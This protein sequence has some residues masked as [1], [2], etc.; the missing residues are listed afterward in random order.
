MKKISVVLYIAAALAI[1]LGST[2]GALTAP[3]PNKPANTTVAAAAG[4]SV[5]SIPAAA[6]RPFEDG[7]DYQNDG[8]YLVH[9]HSPG[10]G[11][12]N[13]WYLAPVHLPQG[14]TITR[15][16]FYFYDD[17]TSDIL[18]WLQRSDLAGNYYNMASVDSAGYS[19]GWGNRSTTTIADPV[20]DNRYN[21]YWVIWDGPVY[22]GAGHEASGVTMVIEYTPPTVAAPGRLSIP[23]AAFQPREDGYDYENHGRYLV[24]KAGATTPSGSFAAPVQLPHGAT[25][26]KM[27]FYY[28]DYGPGAVT[29]TLQRTDYTLGNFVNLASVTSK[30]TGGCSSDYDDTIDYATV[31]NSHYGYWVV[32]DLLAGALDYKGC[33]VVIEYT[34]PATLAGPLSIPAAAFM[35]YEDGYDYE[36]HGRYLKYLHDPNGM[37][38]LGSFYAPVELPHGATVTRVTYYYYDTYVG[39]SGGGINLQRTQFE[40]DYENMAGIGIGNLGQGYSS[41]PDDTIDYATIDNSHYSYWVVLGNLPVS[42]SGADQQIWGCGVVIEYS[43]RLYLPIVLKNY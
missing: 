31:N 22:G 11:T 9:L 8:R 38:A 14:A 7:Y 18:A 43:Y 6:F 23:A 16:T 2:S 34:L 17:S 4:T 15:M 37:L 36:N 20:I 5:L 28:C 39:G 13:G 1:L 42:Q 10:G 35:P 12:A 3:L 19:A 32:W 27:T 40:G 26:T 33:G 21:S 41:Y 29:A 25:I 24:L 30:G